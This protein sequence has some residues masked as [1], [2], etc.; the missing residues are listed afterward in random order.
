MSNDVTFNS[1]TTKAYPVAEKA[2]T[3]FTAPAGTGADPVYFVATATADTN[4]SSGS[5]KQAKTITSDASSP[6]IHYI[7]STNT[8]RVKNI[9]A[10]RINVSVDSS[11]NGTNTVFKNRNIAFGTTSDPPSTDYN[12]SGSIYLYYDS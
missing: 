4:S 6:K 8:L 5:Y 2:K 1:D 10:D 7:P 12:G 3:I 11:A 9:I